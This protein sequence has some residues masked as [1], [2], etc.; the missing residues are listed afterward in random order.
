MQKEII[1]LS[2]GGSLVAPDGIDVGFLKNF[3]AT[4]LRHISRGKRF[5][6]VVGGGKT[7]RNYQD[8][9]T[10]TTTIAA[11]DADWLG[12]EATHMNALLV[13][14]IFGT[15]AHREIIKNPQARIAGFKEKILVAGGWKPGFSTDYDA[16]ILAGQLGARKLV[17]LS[18]IRSV[19]DRDPRKF[20]NAKPITHIAWRDFRK[21]LPKTWK[22]G[23]NAPF[24]PVASREAERLHLEVA[25]MDGTNLKNVDRYLSGTSFIGTVIQ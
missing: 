25:V 1:V 4:I 20:K 10:K 7:A 18:N 15:Y 3:K 21:L 17:N 2:L 16:V 24:D 8:A 13:R 19:Y 23:L 11:S 6:I 9:A 22:P 5:V 12:I 14:T